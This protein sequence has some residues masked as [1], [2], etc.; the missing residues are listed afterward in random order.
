MVNPLESPVAR[1]PLDLVTAL[2]LNFGGLPTPPLPPGPRPGG[3]LAAA[4]PQTLAALRAAL[5]P[6]AAAT[7]PQPV[8]APGYGPAL[9]VEG[10]E[11]VATA[12][13]KA[14]TPPTL[15]RPD[16]ARVAALLPG[17]TDDERRRQNLARIIQGVGG[18]ATV[19]GGGG[20]MLSAMGTG[21]SAAASAEQ[22]AVDAQVAE[23]E[24]QLREWTLRQIETDADL[25]NDEALLRYRDAREDYG[26]ERSEDAAETREQRAERRAREAEDRALTA[27]QQREAREEAR[28]VAQ[29][30]RE[31]ERER[32]EFERE[33]TEWSRRERETQDY[34]IA[35]ERWQARYGTSGRGGSSRSSG[36]SRRTGSSRTTSTDGY[37]ADD[38]EAEIQDLVTAIEEEDDPGKR[39]TLRRQLV[40]ARR[41]Y[42]RLGGTNVEGGGALTTREQA[43]V[44]W[45][46]SVMGSDGSPQRVA[47]QLLQLVQERKMTQAEADTVLDVLG[48]N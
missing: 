36:S 1:R 40:T 13:P 45:G 8:A 18:L 31:A 19:L 41:Q 37:T 35:F 42:R 29:E 27:E 34:K 14:P 10:E 28:R 3:P 30:A 11:Y 7:A 2:G 39:A 4:T 20:T 5:P 26:F 22:Q 17:R 38:F 24:R 16:A 23:R 6:S 12:S 46:R 48:L 33:N 21:A 32:A 9:S 43:Y 25:T 15:V 47:R 44:D